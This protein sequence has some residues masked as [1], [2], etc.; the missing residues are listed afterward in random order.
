M[1]NDLRDSAGALRETGHGTHG[2]YSGSDG[3]VSAHQTMK[4]ATKPRKTPEWTKH[5]AKIQAVLLRSFPK[6][7]DE[8]SALCERQRKRAGVW[9]RFIQL[10]W[11]CREEAGVVTLKHIAQ[12]MKISL[13]KAKDLRVRINRAGLGLRCDGRGSRK[14]PR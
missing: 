2:A 6:I 9:M 12:E 5:N 8:S 3:F 10:Y 13:A 11:R 1:A 7:N 14:R 4:I